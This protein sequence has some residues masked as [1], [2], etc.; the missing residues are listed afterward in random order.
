MI[1][2]AAMLTCSQ[3]HHVVRGVLEHP[4]LTDIQRAE[5]ILELDIASDEKCDLGY[6]RENNNGDV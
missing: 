2:L 5:I 3:V 1:L 6:T 4:H